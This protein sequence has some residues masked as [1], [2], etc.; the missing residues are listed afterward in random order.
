M[1]FDLDKIDIPFLKAPPHEARLLPEG[2]MAGPM[3]WVIAII[4]FLTILGFFLAFDNEDGFEY[5]MW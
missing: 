4:M 2:R 1:K 3:P 5:S